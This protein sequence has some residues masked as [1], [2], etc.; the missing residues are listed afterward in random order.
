MYKWVCLILL[1]MAQFL[2][3]S[4]N[5]L[6]MLSLGAFQN[7]FHATNTQLQMSQ[8]LFSLISATFMVIFGMIGLCT[9]WNILFR[10]GLI[11]I[12]ISE[13]VIFF[14]TSMSSVLFARIMCGCG[15]SMLIPSVLGIMS[16]VYQG[17]DGVI[18]FSVLSMIIGISSS[19][20]PLFFG[21][22]STTFGWKT[23]FL[24]ITI[25]S[26]ILLLCTKILPKRTS[27]RKKDFKFD[28]IGSVLIAI[29]IIVTL[30]AITK[31]T[32]WGVFFSKNTSNISVFGLS[33]VPFMLIIGICTFYILIKYEIHFEQKY[34][35]AGVFPKAF[36]TNRNVN[37][38]FAI[39]SLI[40]FI[41]GASGY[42]YILY[43]QT[44]L[45]FS[46]AMAG[47]VYT[48]YS[49]SAFIGAILVSKLEKHIKIK[50]LL[51]TGVILAG[52]GAFTSIYGIESH[53]IN[54]FLIIGL[55]FSGFGVGFLTAITPILIISS[56]ENSYAQQS[57]GS[58]A[59][60]RNFG[61]VLGV[62]F[63]GILLSMFLTSSFK[64]STIQS[65][66]ID[67]NT[68]E[69]VSKLESID[70]TSN[71]ELK[72]KISGLSKI[73]TR[74]QKSLLSINTESRKEATRKTLLYLSVFIWACLI[75]TFVKQPNPNVVDIKNK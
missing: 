29:P 66:E 71:N 43:M 40:F 24:I 70:F 39:T 59:S 12:A 16:A 4:D 37:L 31:M 8:M 75:L 6:L 74:N 32:D 53:T 68:K 49:A 35:R 62:A 25:I 34:K 14:S 7:V 72:E 2:T 64:S 41:L 63:T 50:S 55:S 56:V 13:M 54:Y 10:T 57:G 44:A 61:Q 51:R 47:L 58:Q 45:G 3:M 26:I 15:A 42:I 60:F 27:E 73:N 23:P 33:L 69:Y 1:C 18:A 22:L 11:F 52:L 19:L 17:K 28:T 20:A 65:K 30:T 48:S 21:F 38:G 5:S 67:K 36:F 9:G 46:S